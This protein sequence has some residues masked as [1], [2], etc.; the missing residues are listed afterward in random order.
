MARLYIGYTPSGAKV[1]R[2]VRMDESG[3][4]LILV[5]Q[6]EFKSVV[7]DLT[8]YLDAGETISSVVTTDENVTA[9]TTLTTPTISVA[10]SAATRT[11]DGCVKIVITLSSGEI[12]R[13][14]LR[15]R[16]PNR[17]GMETYVRD[18]A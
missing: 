7:L 1:Y 15:V 3:E 17:Y 13:Q 18:Y 6:G 5:D 16:R 8:A 11:S 12:I 4:P 2:N 9:T 10:L 14:T